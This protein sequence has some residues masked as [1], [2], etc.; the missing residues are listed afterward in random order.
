MSET[1]SRKSQLDYMVQHKDSLWRIPMA[2]V[3]M[4][5]AEE[6]EATKRPAA[7]EARGSTTRLS[8]PD[9]FKV[10]GT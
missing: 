1:Q 4:V 10:R 8:I 2:L 5:E 6:E 7:Y 3:R 9:A